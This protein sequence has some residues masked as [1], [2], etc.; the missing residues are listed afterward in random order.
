M[1][2]T[3]VFPIAAQLQ[4]YRLEWLSRDVVAGLAIAGVA[5]P[6][7]IAYPA[8]AGLPPETGLYASVLA[9]IGYALFGS[10]RQL[11]VGPDVGTL[12]VLGAA[13][14]QLHLV[15]PQQRVAA[16]ATLTLAVGFLCLVAAAFRCGFIA[17]FLSRPILTGYLC[18]VSLSLLAG[19]IERLTGVHVESPGFLRPLVE[20]AGRLG[21]V[22][23]PT[24]TLGIGLFVLLR[25]LRWRW[26]R[27][28]GP[29]F[30][31]ALGTALSA[32]L[33]LNGVGVALVGKIPVS[34]PS[35]TLLWPGAVAFED[36]FLEAVAV[37]VVSFGSGIIT[38]RSFGAKNRYRVNADRELVGFGAANI[39]SGL[40][41]G[42]AV[43]GADSRTAVNDAIGG[44]TQLAGLVSAAAM[45]VALAVL[46]DILRFLPVAALGAVLASAAVDLL[47][48]AAFRRLWRT[49]RVEFL[50]ALIAAGGVVAIGVLNGVLIAML[51][52]A[53]YLLARVSRPRDALLG[54]IPGRDGLHKLHRE[55][56]AEPIPGLALYLVQSGL[57][58]FNVEYI[59]DRVR[60]IADRLPRGTRWFI[61]D[62]EAV[63]MIDS[64][65]AAVLDEIRGD[66]ERRECRLGLANLHSRPRRMLARAGL[67]V[68]LGPDMVFD[69][70]EDAVV[71]F[72]HR[73][74]NRLQKLG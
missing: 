73:P 13:L 23:V 37:L 15:D 60:W 74:E 5:L 62:C 7:G 64:T 22:S 69:R 66:L 43:T 33:H 26:R 29:L 70:L 34:L 71:A 25:L 12:T 38:A 42:F 55:P 19:Q 46:T 24:A 4:T 68:K 63:T 17:N 49:D 3:A 10:S 41:G 53:A 72:E 50:L 47:D 59:R 51:A 2:I 8:I 54:R 48:I 56:K 28:P 45:I 35:P 36:F 32:L 61:V 20:L 31:L 11:I 1:R 58:F 44:R 16:A 57:I 21:L 14:Y 6:V 67:I 30:A 18:G 27:A 39:A 40:F 65:A 9:L 52:T